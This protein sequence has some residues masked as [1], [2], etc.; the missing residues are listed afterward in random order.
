[1]L[2]N[3]WLNLTV[4]L[5]VFRLGLVTVKYPSQQ[6]FSHVGVL[7]FRKTVDKNFSNLP[8]Y[9]HELIYPIISMPLIGHIIMFL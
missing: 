2:D 7:R 9:H 5:M 6:F 8:S 3:K 1:M 4:I